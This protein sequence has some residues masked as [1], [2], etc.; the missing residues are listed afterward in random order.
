MIISNMACLDILPR[1]P[2]LILWYF[3]NVKISGAYWFCLPPCR[4]PFSVLVNYESHPVLLGAI[5]SKFPVALT[6]DAYISVPNYNGL[7]SKYIYKLKFTV[8]NL[9]HIYAHLRSC[10]YLK[11]IQIFIL[12]T[13]IFIY[14]V[15]R[16][17]R[18]LQTIAKNA[19]EFSWYIWSQHN[20]HIKYCILSMKLCNETVHWEW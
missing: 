12:A 19:I 7:C 13:T 18:S 8:C 10:G 9:F 2:S 5:Y 15:P 14:H 11:L 6:R 17:I 1:L 16:L 3:D 20:P 4:V